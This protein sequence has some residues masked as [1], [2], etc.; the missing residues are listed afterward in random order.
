[1]RNRRLVQER[2]RWA[3]LIRTYPAALLLVLAG[4]VT[5]AEGKLAKQPY[6]AGAATRSINPDPD[7]S[8][9]IAWQG[10]SVGSVRWQLLGDH[11]RLNALAAVAGA[12]PAWSADRVVDLV[13]R[14]SFR[15]DAPA[16]LRLPADF[17]AYARDTGWPVPRSR[18]AASLVSSSLDEGSIS[19]FFFVASAIASS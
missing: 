3:T 13:G 10:K 19:S 2:N 14:R 9:E 1:M 16:D 12:D 4:Q 11:N 8:F 7:G 5:V 6:L 17:T 18:R 15:F